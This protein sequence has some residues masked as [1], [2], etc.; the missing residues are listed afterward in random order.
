M[1]RDHGGKN[2]EIINFETQIEFGS[3]ELYQQREIRKPRNKESAFLA[4][5]YQMKIIY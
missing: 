3:K 1:T 2:K 4:G 5:K